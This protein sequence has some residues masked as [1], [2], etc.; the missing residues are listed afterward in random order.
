MEYS[1][2]D[3]AALLRRHFARVELYGQRR[4]QSRRHRVASTPGR[5][6]PAQTCLGFLRQAAPLVGTRAVVD[7][8]TADIVIEQDG[9]DRAS[10][11][12]AVCREPRVRVAHL[13]VG[14]EIAGGQIV[15]LELARAARARG[16]DALFVTPT[17]GAFVDLARRDSFSV[18]VLPF[19]G[20]LDVG[21]WLRLRAV[22]R[23]ERV[24][25]CIP[26]SISLRM[27]WAGGGAAGRG[28]GDLAHA[29][30]KRLPHRRPDSIRTGRA[31]QRTARACVEH[32]GRIRRH[33]TALV[34]PGLSREKAHDHPQRSRA[35]PA[36]ATR[37]ERVLQTW[38][39]SAERGPA[40][41]TKGQREL[42]ERSS[43]AGDDAWLILVGEDVERGGAY[44]RELERRGGGLGIR[45]RR[46]RRLPS[47]RGRAACRDGRL[48]TALVDRRFA[49]HRARSDGAGPARGCERRRRHSRGGR[50]RRDRAARAA[51]QPEGARPRARRSARN[52]E[53]AAGS[54][55]AVVADRGGVLAERVPGA[56]STCTRGAA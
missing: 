28:A 14:G 46:H 1:P 39:P 24:D 23:E 12:V 50:R 55:E 30:R 10:E 6:R 54:G 45:Q 20:A 11:L 56:S 16:H 36:R 53:R 13:L 25:L 21:G 44:R 40:R 47:R 33:A 22:L 8:T 42:L 48:R 17:H 15:A 38:P 26:T 29:R 2:D 7:L 52:P 5:V 51:P 4:L 27:W 35:A 19:R 34:R 41:A 9:I 43:A 37:P 3:F 31:R 32:R 18:H 49:D